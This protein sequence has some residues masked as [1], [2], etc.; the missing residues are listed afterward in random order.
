MSST[1]SAGVPGW[2]VTLIE[3]IA[4]LIF[5]HEFIVA[6]NSCLKNLDGKDRSKTSI[7]GAEN[8]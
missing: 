6:I 2:V 7:V 4:A 8:N 5:V 3:N 1:K